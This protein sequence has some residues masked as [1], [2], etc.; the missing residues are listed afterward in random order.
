MSEIF[1]GLTV[2][3]DAVSE[4]DR[5]VHLL[6]S[7]PESYNMLVNALEEQSENILEWEPVTERLLHQESKLKEKVTVPLEDGRKALTA[8]Q[9]KGFRK[10]FTCHYCHKPGHFKKDCRKYLAA[11]KNKPMWPRKSK[12]QAAMEKHL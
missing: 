9:N 11:Q 10:T 6:A 1:E 8:G 2:I 5:V 3:G 4:E 12:P 7:L